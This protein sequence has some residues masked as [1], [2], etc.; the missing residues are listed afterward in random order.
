[1]IINAVAVHVVHMIARVTVV[2][3]QWS[4]SAVAVHVLPDGPVSRV[5][6]RIIRSICSE[7]L[8]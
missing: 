6:F 1:M 3:R 8:G 4:S 7:L 2:Y 5:L